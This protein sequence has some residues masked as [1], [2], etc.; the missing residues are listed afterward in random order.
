MQDLLERNLQLISSLTINTNHHGKLLIESF[1][2]NKTENLFEFM[3]V[4]Q[5]EFLLRIDDAL[6]YEDLE[7][8]FEYLKSKNLLS[9]KAVLLEDTYVIK[10]EVCPT[11]YEYD[12][13]DEYYYKTEILIKYF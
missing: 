7:Y 5:P 12:F 3:N 2:D 6:D 1:Y 10:R 8:I 4:E 11:S 9:D 13:K